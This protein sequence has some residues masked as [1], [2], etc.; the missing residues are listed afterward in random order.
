SLEF[1]TTGANGPWTKVGGTFSATQPYIT[2]GGYNGNITGLGGA[3]WSGTSGLTNGSFNTTTVNVD[4]L[5]GQTAW[6]AF[7]YFSDITITLEGHYLDD[8]SITTD[9]P[10]ACTTGSTP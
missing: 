10:Q 8:V 9:I 5:A 6:F 7:H 4:A 2:G 3:C 1:S